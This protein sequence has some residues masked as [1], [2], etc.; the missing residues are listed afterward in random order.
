MARAGREAPEG[1]GTPW[2]AHG[3]CPGGSPTPPQLLVTKGAQPP[4]PLCEIFLI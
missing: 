1:A 2:G 3:L 4:E